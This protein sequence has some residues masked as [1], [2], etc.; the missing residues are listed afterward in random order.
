MSALKDLTGQKFGRLT[1]I[2]RTEN[3]KKGRARWLCKCECGKEVVVQGGHLR[4][5]HTSSCGCLAKEITSEASL[6]D[7]TGQRFGRLT[8]IKRVENKGN[9]PRWLCQC[10]CGN[11]TVVA[12]RHLRNGEV[13]SCGC[14]VKEKN[15]TL[16][17]KHGMEGTKIYH[18]WCGIKNRCFNS[19]EKAYKHYG[20]RGITIFAEWID[21]FQKFYDYVSKLPHYGEDGYSIDRIDNNGN[22]E[23]DNLRWAD[24]KTQHRNKRDNHLVQYGDRWVTIAEASEITG[25]PYKTL[26]QRLKRG[27]TGEKLYRPVRPYKK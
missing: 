16:H 9:Q 26:W 22:Y 24:D 1:V 12:G 21:D 2:S 11:Q 7:L 25:I 10:E 13:R 15:S 14:L 23:P 27:D 18:V 6:K 5:G 4:S 3:D 19:N 20:G 17:T 8:V